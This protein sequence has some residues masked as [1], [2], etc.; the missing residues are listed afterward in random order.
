MEGVL[1]Q[2]RCPIIADFYKKI[3]GVFRSSFYEDGMQ[4]KKSFFM[5]CS[6]WMQESQSRRK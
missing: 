3:V 4:K 2:V 5:L 1:L 6:L